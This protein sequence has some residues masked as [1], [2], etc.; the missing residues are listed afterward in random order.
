MLAFIVCGHDK[1]VRGWHRGDDT[2]EVYD[3]LSSIPFISSTV[4]VMV[5]SADYVQ[6]QT[7]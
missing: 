1:Q 5:Q 4:K 7:A 3:V 2:D 6:T